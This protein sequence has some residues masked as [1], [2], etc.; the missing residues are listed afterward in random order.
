M[1]RLRVF[2]LVFSLAL[3]VPIGY[4]VV[5]TETGL[6]RQ[7]ESEFR[8]FAQAL[9]NR[10]EE[11]LADLVA[12]EEARDIDDYA[13]VTDGVPSPL[14]A[15]PDEPWLVGWLQND[16]DGS[17]RTPLSE[18]ALVERLDQA[19]QAFNELRAAT[20][21]T[22]PLP[23]PT[24]ETLAQAP[25][26]E[27][28]DAGKDFIVR[29]KPTATDLKEL[30]KQKEEALAAKEPPAFAQRYLEEPATSKKSVLGQEK[31]R[32]EQVP[33]AQAQNI[34]PLAKGPATTSESVDDWQASPP[35]PEPEQESQVQAMLDEL[36]LEPEV[37]VGG[38]VP[39]VPVADA[40][41]SV[42][43]APL[44]AVDLGDDTIFLF[45]SVVLDGQVFRQ[46]VVLD[47]QGLA[48]HLVKAYF[49]D[50]PM[51]R[52]AQLSL[53]VG[54]KGLPVSGG[55]DVDEPR[56]S[57]SRVFPRPFD[58]LTASLACQDVPPAAG[59]T[60]LRAM[61]L[62]LGAVVLLGLVA[63]YQSA[64]VVVDHS[65]RRTQFV[66]SVTHE[67][68]TPLTNLRMYIEMLE[69]GMA[70]TPERER[71]YLEVLASESARLSKLIENVL[72][73]SRLESRRRT[74]E[75]QEGDLSE[76]AEAVARAMDKQLSEAGFALDVD[77]QPGLRAMYDREAMIQ[78]LMNLMENSLKFGAGG[79]DKRIGLAARKAGDRV[80]VTVSDT[81]PGI[82]PG[83]LKKV[84]D[85]FY[86]VEA[87][88][89]RTTK[90]T[91]IGLA[92]VKRFV[93]AMNGRVWAENNPKG[94]CTMTIALPG[95]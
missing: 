82:P 59:R 86:R 28:K 47:A 30:K 9:F 83:D 88:L 63:I 1:N 23:V 70:P 27:A 87:G 32:V 60:T 67:L 8:F 46:G 36:T 14:A 45:R 52:F 91:G 72:E 4:L 93:R 7:E 26:P 6:N 77:L 76:V 66:S 53:V 25:E 73:F 22:A 20:P 54:D 11:E 51:A 40:P 49:L 80:L 58:F 92:L 74:L 69:Q 33:Q 81:G 31:V 56:L 43:V 85:D 19:N 75:L 95:A 29:D 24:S 71:E 16:P 37:A 10:M 78:V 35:Q 62:V 65:Q 89:T 84:F 48:T 42:E 2:M 55:V 13:A 94:G 50:Q 41:V 34:A 38:A 5:R 12:R 18:P 90:G 17:M 57:L 3:A 79:A 21:T 61:I 15:P 44:Q 64:R 68:K 39:E